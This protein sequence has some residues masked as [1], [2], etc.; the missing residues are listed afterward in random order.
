[1]EGETEERRR[2]ERV[3]VPFEWSEEFVWDGLKEMC[4]AR[5]DPQKCLAR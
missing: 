3:E 1:M 5:S 2:R 4:Q